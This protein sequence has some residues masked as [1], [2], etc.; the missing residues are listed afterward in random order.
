MKEWRV[1]TAMATPFGPDLSLDAAG[2]R[3]LARH[4]AATG[5][6][7]IVVAGSTGESPTLTFDEKLELFRTVR[8]ATGPQTGVVAGCGSNSTADTVRLSRE[9]E[10]VGVDGI[11]LVAPY[12]N[13]PPQEALYRHFLAVA[14]AVSIPIMVYN[15]PGRT[16][17]N[18]LPETV[19]R[20][21]AVPN[22]AALKEASGNLDQVSEVIRV[23]PDSF[24][25]FSGD[26]S[27]TLPILAVGGRGVVSVASHVAGQQIRAMILAYEAGRVSEAR[28]LHT[29]LLPLFKALFVTSNP[30]PLK[31]AL[32]LLGL[33]GGGLRPPLMAA[34][35]GEVAVVRAAMKATGIPV[36]AE[37]VAL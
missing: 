7:A 15:V 11:M 12:Y 33:P 20:L 4:L 35:A 19:A 18:L 8:E 16:G 27:L 9:A 21:A 2:A 22:I 24:A 3:K 10:K 36:N 29:H 31:A 26:D 17:V 32:A 1:L 37:G 25:V 28:R 13:K 14:E 30:I 23:V 5:S 6:D 34:T